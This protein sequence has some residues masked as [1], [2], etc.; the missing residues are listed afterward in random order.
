MI[1]IDEDKKKNIK[2]ANVGDIVKFGTFVFDSIDFNKGPAYWKVLKRLDCSNLEEDD[3][4]C[5]NELVG[6][7]YK[8]YRGKVLIVFNDFNERVWGFIGVTKLPSL[9]YRSLL[10]YYYSNEWF[11]DEFELVCPEYKHNEFPVQLDEAEDKM[12]IKDEFYKGFI[13]YDFGTIWH[14]DALKYFGE[15]FYNRL[16]LYQKSRFNG[17][18]SIN[19]GNFSE[20][21]YGCLF[22]IDPD[23]INEAEDYKKYADDGLIFKN[24]EHN[25]LFTTNKIIYTFDLL[26]GSDG[27]WVDLAYIMGSSGVHDE[28]ACNIS[29]LLNYPYQED[30]DAND[31]A[32]AGSF[33]KEAMLLVKILVIKI[34][35]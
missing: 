9:E 32:G 26:D 8:D 29:E 35:E 16:E 30:V 19:H 13:S 31:L 6:D 23:D 1:K 21:N 25:Y 20:D 22:S 15:D 18:I 17:L 34:P 28:D 2:D 5:L 4:K 12:L 33:F 24:Y 14:F 3:K 11:E 27:N 7:A 10:T